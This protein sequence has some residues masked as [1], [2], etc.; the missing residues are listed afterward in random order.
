M[1][2]MEIAFYEIVTQSFF[3]FRQNKTLD[4]ELSTEKILPLNFKSVRSPPQRPKA[5]RA[6]SHL[7]STYT[8]SPILLHPPHT[9]VLSLEP[10]VTI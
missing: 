1:F 3:Y 4:L 2:F 6:P 10:W 9:F 5:P 7:C 8:C